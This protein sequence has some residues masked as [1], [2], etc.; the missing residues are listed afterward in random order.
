MGLTR[1]IESMS[2]R[3]AREGLTNYMLPS[4]DGGWRDIYRSG[5]LP[6][7]FNQQWGGA[8]WGAEMQDAV[9]GV[10]YKFDVATGQVQDDSTQAVDNISANAALA[11]RFRVSESIT[12]AA[13]W[14]KVYKVGN[15][16]T[17]IG[18]GIQTAPGTAL[19]SQYSI[20]GK[21]ITS[22]ADGEWVRFPITGGILTANTD[23]YIGIDTS[24]GSVDASNYFVVKTTVSSKQPYGGFY[25]YN[26]TVWTSVLTTTAF[27]FLI[28]PA[29]ANKFIQSSGQFDKKLVFADSTPVN[30]SKSLSQP[31]KNFFDGS[32]FTYLVRGNSWQK[33]KPIA[34]FI[35][36]L[37]H[38]RISL[39]THGT[40]GAAILT[41][42]NQAGVSFVIS[43]TTD[44]STVGNKDVAIAIR[45]VG[46][47]SDYIKLY[48]NGVV[49]G[50][51]ITGQ[52]IVFDSL[53]RELGTAWLGGGFSVTPTWS[54]G[55]LSSFASLPSSNGWTWTGTATEANAMSVSN[56][57][58]YQNKNGYASTDA[59]YY[60]KSSAG[61][62]NTTGWTVT[63]KSRV[64]FSTNDTNG[65]FSLSVNDGSKFV[66]IL[67]QEYFVQS[68][69]SSV[70]FTVQGDFKSQEHVFT[71]CGKGSDYYLFID[72]KLAI[73][74]TGKLLVAS[75]TNNINFGDAAT[76][77]G[78]NSDGIWTYVKY[79]T[80]GMLIP[81][82]STGGS[83]SE[84]V[85]WSGDK[86]G[87]LKDLYNSGTPISAKTY[88]GF[89]KNYIGEGFIQ[90]VLVQGVTVPSTSSLTPVILPDMEL[91]CL[92]SQLDI[93]R[94]AAITNGAAGSPISVLRVDGTS[95]PVTRG[96]CY[97]SVA[98]ENHTQNI[99]E[100]VCL[101]LHKLDV[102]YYTD[103]SSASTLQ[104][105]RNLVVEAKY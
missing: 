97:T 29:T 96:S 9:T 92:G 45:A 42:Y 68:Y 44:L 79:Y 74:G 72:G 47:T 13:I 39:T 52:A 55:S 43:G 28:E 26:G 66:Q 33:G 12:A 87:T 91:F 69:G 62:N 34:D 84:T 38:D 102:Q 76:G 31:M 25:S 93:N 22:K 57:K 23:Y 5:W 54:L 101:G 98:T 24:A 82:A 86:T 53:F 77:A 103:S 14:L 105:S 7:W 99:K 32:Q 11:T 71:L 36:G 27:C 59:G 65:N 56:S 18:V 15:P 8:Q 3:Q 37:D 70:D 48:V 1:V 63:W 83:V 90:R 10:T 30:Q 4:S 17:T 78:I 35:Y 40:T 21:N 50:V 2:V 41:V 100:S 94:W 75:A 16:S 89:E 81:Q 51:S 73:D 60:V 6:S 80:N 58:L 104:Q 64:S 95:K 19:S 67:I 85:F 61:L 20:S 46:D 88:M 49:E